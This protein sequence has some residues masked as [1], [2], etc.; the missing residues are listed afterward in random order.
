MPSRT[1]VQPLSSSTVQTLL[2]KQPVLSASEKAM[3]LLLQVLALVQG[4]CLCWWSRLR[5]HGRSL[6]CAVLCLNFCK[7]FL[8]NACMNNRRL[9]EQ[10]RVRP[11]GTSVGAPALLYTLPAQLAVEM[12]QVARVEHRARASK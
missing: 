9:Q 12:G 8:Q 7:H 4:M 10:P 2:S 3:V 5:A 11:D 6:V 1:V